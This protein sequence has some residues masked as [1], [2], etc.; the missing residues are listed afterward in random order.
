MKSEDEKS[1]GLGAN[2]HVVFSE[3]LGFDPRALFAL[4]IRDL[5]TLAAQRPQSTEMFPAL[6]D[7]RDV[8]SKK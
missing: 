1:T 5:V 4:A 8:G 2:Y 6:P 3:E 7:L